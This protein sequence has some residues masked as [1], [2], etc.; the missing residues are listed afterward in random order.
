MIA[1]LALLAVHFELSSPYMT[2]PLMSNAS[3]LSLRPATALDADLIA[4]IHAASWQ[5]TYRGLLPD[6]FLDGEVTRERAAYW[7]ARLNAPGAERRNVVIAER[8]GEPIGFACVERQPDSAW[9]VLLD[10][11]HALPGHQGIGVG[12]LLMQAAVD[13]TRAQGESRLYLYVLEGNTPAIGFYERQGWKFAG[14]EPDHM[15]GVDITALRYVYQ[16]D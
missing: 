4:S 16:L 8:A 11:L 5:A 6:A 3:A 1:P 2:V 13:W 10:N 14:A 7:Q 15:G 9:G 12:K